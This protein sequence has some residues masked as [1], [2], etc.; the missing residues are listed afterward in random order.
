MQPF[1]EQ[2]FIGLS[3]ASILLLGALGLSFTFGQ[4]GVINMAHGEL[5]MAGAFT[6]HRVCLG[7]P[8]RFPLRARDQV[9]SWWVVNRLTWR[10][11]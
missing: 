1:L 4:M 11:R 8:P 2:L 3:L 6:R 10:D 5:I 9:A 7:L